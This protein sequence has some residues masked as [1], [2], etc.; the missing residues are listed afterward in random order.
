[1]LNGLTKDQVIY[2][3]W[4]TSVYLIAKLVSEHWDFKFHLSISH[5]LEDLQLREKTQ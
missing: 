3:N 2:F 4:K 5:A 1:M